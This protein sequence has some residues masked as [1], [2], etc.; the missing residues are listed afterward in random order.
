MTAEPRSRHPSRD[1]KAA[2]LTGGLLFLVASGLL[3]IFSGGGSVATQSHMAEVEIQGPILSAEPTLSLIE[4]ARERPE[5]KGVLLRVNSPGGGVGASESL[6]KAVARLSEEKPVAV[7]LGDMAASGGY[8][9]ALGGDRIF[10]LDSTLTGSIG[11]IMMSTGVYP[12]LDKI[13]VVPRIIKSGRFKDAG[14]PLREMSEED[15]DYLQ[16]MVDEL[17]GQF[18]AMVAEER[19]ME[20]GEVRPLADGRVFSGS[21]ARS[22]GLVDAVGGRETALQWLRE[23]AQLGPEA[24]IRTLEAPEGWLRQVLPAG[25]FNWLQLRFAPEPRY[26]YQGG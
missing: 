17:H 16:S 2:W 11:V 7:S 21:Q 19:G 23:E 14:S 20:P 24:P 13:G 3:G 1:S 18:V 26:L 22:S 8:M 6:Y 15:R 5:V 25:L 9:V 10:A 12:L 4:D